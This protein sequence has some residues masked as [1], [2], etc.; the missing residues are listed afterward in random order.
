MKVERVKWV[1]LLSLIAAG[2]VGAVV[3]T[4]PIPSS[5]LPES[6]VARWV[7]TFSLR[8]VG[9]VLVAVWAVSSFYI[10][11]S[12]LGLTTPKDAGENDSP[13]R[14]ELLAALIGAEGECY[15]DLKPEGVVVIDGQ[16]Y[17]ARAESIV[18]HGSRVK[19]VGRKDFRLLVEPL[20]ESNRPMQDDTR[21]RVTDDAPR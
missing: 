10:F 12:S 2:M 17:T 4:Y 5:L 1:A 20:V 13:N 7:V 6:A 8:L 19:V 16:R 15:C 14:S 21:S 18:P 9:F 11:G 3:V